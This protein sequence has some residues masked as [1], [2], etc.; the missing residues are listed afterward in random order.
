MNLLVTGAWQD[1]EAYM[2]ELE[3]MGHSAVF[4]KWEKDPLPCEAE[5]VEGVICNGL[6]LHHPIERFPNLRFIQ[7]TSAGFDRVDMDYA[8]AHGIEVHNARG[9]YSIP[10]AEFALAGV[11][12][13]YKQ[14][15][16]FEENRAARRWEKHR[17][18]LEL[19]GKN[20]VVV[21]CGSVGSECAKRFSAMGCHV[22]GV[23]IAVREDAAFDRM[24]PLDGLEEA[25]K[26]ADVLILCVPLTDKTDGLLDKARLSLLPGSAVVVNIARGR[27]VDEAALA[28]M[29]HAGRLFGAVLD[30]FETEPLPP[31]SPLWDAPNTVLTPHNSFVSDGIGERLGKCVK[32]NLFLGEKHD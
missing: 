2:D 23:D 1:A 11:L 10:M 31:S 16:F 15:R 21:G 7:L 9:V 29:L 30:V 19:Y 25:L 3:A 4:L 6:F 8:S 28:A 32:N 13:L 18:L 22:T 17:G 24:L 5:W 14:A 20:V 27:V 26:A 12:Q